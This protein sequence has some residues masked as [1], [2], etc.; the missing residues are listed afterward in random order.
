MLI[1][2]LYGTG[3]TNAHRKVLWARGV[4][5]SPGGVFLSPQGDLDTA[6]YSLFLQSQ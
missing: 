4:Y 3:K 1:R 6:D 2:R 5:L